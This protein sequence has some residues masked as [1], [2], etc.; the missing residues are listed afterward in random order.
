MKQTLL[1]FELI[2]TRIT[3]R[4]M[5]R[6]FERIRYGAARFYVNGCYMNVDYCFFYFQSSQG[7]NEETHNYYFLP[8]GKGPVGG[9]GL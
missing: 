9:M 4:R 2:I 8:F 6:C 7:F 1:Y 3:I 5:E